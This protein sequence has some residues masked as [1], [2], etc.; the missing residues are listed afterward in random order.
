MVRGGSKGG[1]LQKMPRIQ[2]VNTR[3]VEILGHRIVETPSWNA[4]IQMVE[5]ITRF[6]FTVAILMG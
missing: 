3:T 1:K 5:K 6:A 4:L 2:R